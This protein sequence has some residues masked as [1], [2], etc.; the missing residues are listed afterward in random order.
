MS[1]GRGARPGAEVFAGWGSLGDLVAGR[2][3]ATTPLGPI[4][5][6]PEPLR[7]SVGLCL[8]SPFPMIVLWG[9]ELRNFYNDA[10]LPIL[11]DKHPGALGTPVAQIWP[12]VWPALRPHIDAAVAGGTSLAEDGLWLLNRRGFIEEC[13]VTLAFS[14]I[15]HDGGVG[16]V[17]CVLHEVTGTIVG[18]RRLGVLRDIPEACAGLLDAAEVCAAAA[19]VLAGDPRDMPFTAVYRLDGGVARRT[20]LTGL[21]DDDPRA[22]AAVPLGGPDDVWDLA[23]SGERLVDGLRARFG[24]PDDA[25]DRAVVLPIPVREG[26]D[27]AVLVAAVSPMRPLDADYR[28][29]LTLVAKAVGTELDQ[30]G[31]LAAERA[32]VAALA[33]LD[34]AKTE[35]F[36]DVSHEFR[37]PLTLLLGPL[38]DA[39]DD[40]AEALGPRQR[41]RVE[42][43]RRNALRLQRLVDNLLDFSR[44][45]ADRAQVHTEPTD[46]AAFTAE[47]AGV[48]RSAIERAGLRLE[49]SAPALPRPVP[50]D[51]QMWE[52]V[53]LNLLSNAVKFTFVGSIS[54]TVRDDGD[55][56]EVV[57]ADTGVGIAAADLPHVFDR[58][59]RVRGVR[60]RSHEGTGIG[61]AL[62]RDLLAAHGATIAVD[63]RPGEGAAF[64]VR[65]PYRSAHPVRPAPADELRLPVPA[66]PSASALP[67]LAEARTWVGDTAAPAP[68]AA[69]SDERPVLLLA[70]DNP[71]MAGYLARILDGQWQVRRWRT[72]AEALAAALA[73]P[74]DL[75]LADVMMPVMDG[76]E[77]VRRLRAEP[78]TAHLPIV[79]LTARAG[80]DAALEGLAAGADDYLTK[81]FAAADLQARLH[82]RYRLARGRAAAR[83][84]PVVAAVA[85]TRRV[86]DVPRVPGALRGIRRAVQRFLADAG[87]DRSEVD[88]LLLAVGEAAANFVDHRDTADDDAPLRMELSATGRD[89]EILLTAPGPFLGRGAPA[90]RGRGAPLMASEADVLVTPGADELTVRLRRRLGVPP[91]G[92]ATG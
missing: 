57:V 32:R 63:S 48:F 21:P 23:A 14:P 29:F 78:V 24:S 22:P 92:S 54:V 73:D 84:A 90:G 6:W 70:E 35:F 37:T 42:L 43:A 40:A 80:Q 75:V 13:Y 49:V 1:G 53:V 33:A 18:A 69:G 77:L 9:P 87:A 74:P 5:D 88:G 16:G 72:G 82:S 25:P 60:S 4:A 89:V 59:Y 39:Q 7:T 12:E 10:Y 17:L 45:E 2:D 91:A 15:P 67:Y 34:R 3:W 38:Q 66:A 58:F 55:A 47:L 52:K 85:G 41:E 50:V 65:V 44:V 56:A 62:V 28:S 11:A 20:A 31:E 79:L 8:R 81:P 36:S 71:D 86:L 30:A 76:V 68:T 27:R 26:A 61:L 64:T 46:L 83:P 51:R 19:G